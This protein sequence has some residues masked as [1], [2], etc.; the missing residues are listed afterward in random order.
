MEVGAFSNDYVESRGS[1][2]LRQK[3]HRLISKVDLLAAT[4]EGRRREI[5]ET[6]A[7]PALTGSIESKKYTWKTIK[8]TFFCV[9]FRE[10]LVH[11][12][13]LIGSLGKL[14]QVTEDIK[15]IEEILV[16]MDADVDGKLEADLILEVLDLVS[17][18]KGVDINAKEMAKLVELLKKED[19][20]EVIP[21]Q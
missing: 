21:V 7:D 18:H 6:V 10:R 8:R 16:A 1:K 14:Q 9:C 19:M 11:I 12:K 20:L 13:D 3:V 4:L 15:R 5:K 2:K 17:K